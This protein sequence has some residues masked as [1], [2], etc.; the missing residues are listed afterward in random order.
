MT[1]NLVKHIAIIQSG[2]VIDI[3]VVDELNET[4]RSVLNSHF[5]NPDHLIEISDDLLPYITIGALWND[6][7]FTPINSPGE[8]WGW[9]SELKTWKIIV[10]QPPLT[11]PNNILVW[12]QETVSWGETTL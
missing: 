3:S 2:A 7:V 10:P 1:D 4:S 11:D 6:G 9:D 12:D 5:N 8:G